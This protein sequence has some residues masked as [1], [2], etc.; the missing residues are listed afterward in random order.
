MFTVHTLELER[1]LVRQKMAYQNTVQLIILS[2]KSVK[3]IKIE[4]VQRLIKF[5]NF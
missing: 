5:K 1:L 4:L 2:R 3:M